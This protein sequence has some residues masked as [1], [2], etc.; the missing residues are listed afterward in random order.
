MTVSTTVR[1][2]PDSKT[3]PSVVP[4]PERVGRCAD[5]RWPPAVLVVVGVGSGAGVGEAAAPLPGGTGQLSGRIPSLASARSI[6]APHPSRSVIHR[7]ITEIPLGVLVTTARS[8][9]ATP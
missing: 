6:T 7:P 9:L 5:R 3:G 2:R 1:R 8:S 4:P